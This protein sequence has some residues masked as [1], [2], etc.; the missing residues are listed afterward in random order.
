[1]KRRLNPNARSKKLRDDAT[2]GTYR[3]VYPSCIVK[4]Q[5]WYSS[6]YPKYQ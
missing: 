2:S 6:D 5:E 1:M 3:I 4:I